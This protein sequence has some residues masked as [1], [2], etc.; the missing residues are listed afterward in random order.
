MSYSNDAYAI[1]SY[2][3]D[4]AAG[5]SLESFLEERIFRPLGMTRTVLDL[6]GSE[7]NKLGSDGNI[8]EL[9]EKDEDGNLYS[10]HRSL[11][12][13]QKFHPHRHVSLI[14]SISI[15]QLGSSRKQG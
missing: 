5:Q 11:P 1:L 7:A 9:F 10:R 6:D 15:H 3:V 2:V 8:T 14:A 4:K 12:T 13:I